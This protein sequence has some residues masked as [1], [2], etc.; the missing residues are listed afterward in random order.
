[1]ACNAQPF[2]GTRALVDP[3]QQG[4]DPQ[5]AQRDMLALGGEEMLPVGHVP[6]AAP[7]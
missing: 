3:L 7:A 5:V 1:M 4:R 6:G 2:S